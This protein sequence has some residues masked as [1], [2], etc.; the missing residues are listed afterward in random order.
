MA[1]NINFK[2]QNTFENV[3]I[4]KFNNRITVTYR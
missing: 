3:I 1:T 2:V 4:I